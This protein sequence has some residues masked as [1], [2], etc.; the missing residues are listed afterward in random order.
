MDYFVTFCKFL[1]KILEFIDLCLNLNFKVLWKPK[2]LIIK[3]RTYAIAFKAK[4]LLFK[5]TINSS[6][7]LLVNCSTIFTILNHLLCKISTF[8]SRACYAKTTT[9]TLHDKMT[10]LLYVWQNLQENETI[11]FIR[12]FFLHKNK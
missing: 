4:I 8:F 12:C 3:L 5:F 2:Y 6:Q 11:K 1:S 9:S 10:K 7:L